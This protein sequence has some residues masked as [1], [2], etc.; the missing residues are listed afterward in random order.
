MLRRHTL[1]NSGSRFARRVT[2]SCS[3]AAIPGVP[4][5]DRVQSGGGDGFL[6]RP[7]KIPFL[8]VARRWSPFA[9]ASGSVTLSELC[10]FI[11]IILM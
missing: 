6:F 11:T 4:K 9:A 1:R 8:D 2:H 3:P 10:L 7:S 5:S